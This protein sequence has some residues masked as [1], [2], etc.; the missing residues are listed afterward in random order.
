MNLNENKTESI[1][2]E[3]NI[4]QFLKQGNSI[5]PIIALNK[6]NCFRLGARI[7]ALKQKGYNIKTT[8]VVTPSRKR[9]A[10]YYLV[11]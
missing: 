10:S 2:Q 7:Y 3:M 4:L 11:D 1:S 6:F 8:K 9:I 5:T